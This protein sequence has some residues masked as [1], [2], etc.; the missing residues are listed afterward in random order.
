MLDD[1]KTDLTG[2]IS[3]ATYRE[4][5]DWCAY[6]CCTEVELAEAIAVMGHGRDEVRAFLRNGL[7]A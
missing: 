4:I 7:L 1:P 5:R 3:I 6:F 2:S